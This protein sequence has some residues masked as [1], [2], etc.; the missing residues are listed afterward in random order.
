MLS[1]AMKKMGHFLGLFLILLSSTSAMV[2]ASMMRPVSVPFNKSYVASWGADH[3]KQLNG[4]R[5][6]ELLLNKEHGK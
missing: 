2:A 4:G 3:I 1:E 5:N 6:V